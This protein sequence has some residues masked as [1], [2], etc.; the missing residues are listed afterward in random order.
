M[1][2]I[3]YACYRRDL[4]ESIGGIHMKCLGEYEPYFPMATG[5]RMVLCRKC[6]QCPY[7]NGDVARFRVRR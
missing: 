2:E 7:Y 3:S 4:Y 6:E 1:I 5:G